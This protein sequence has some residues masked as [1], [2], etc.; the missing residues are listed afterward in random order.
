MLFNQTMKRIAA[1]GI[2]AFSCTAVWAEPSALDIIRKMDVNQMSKTS[3]T[4][5]TMSVYPDLSNADAHRDMKVR[6]FGR[7]EDDS[8]MEFIE[9]AMIRG[10]RILSKGDNRWVYFPS[11]GRKRKIAGESKK[12]SV[13]GVGG[14]FSYEDLGGGSFE[15]KYSVK[16]LNSTTEQW[17][18]EGI[19]KNESAY[20]R[21]VVHVDKKT[22]VPVRTEYFTK[23]EGHY[24]TLSGVDIQ[25]I[26]GK[27]IAT[28]MTMKNLAKNRKTTVQIHS[29][30]YDMPIDAKYFDANRFY[31]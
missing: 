14:D 22:F 30:D 27:W 28:K 26:S 20:S 16:L 21:V 4:V 8:Y 15:S 31:N 24:K 3:S 7:G 29:V 19:P 10:L 11:T 5:M 1:V 9:P 6:S 2:V 17:V 18:L 12:E 25:R 13:K 23:E